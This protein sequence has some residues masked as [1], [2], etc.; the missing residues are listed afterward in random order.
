MNERINEDYTKY[1]EIKG[2]IGGGAFGIVY[3]GIEKK[4]KEL[5]AMKV[6]NLNDYK[7][8]LLEYCKNN[9]IEKQYSQKLEEYKNHLKNEF[10]IMKQLSGNNNSVKCYEY[11]SNDQY[12]VIIMEL[13]DKNLKNW[14]YET[15]SKEKRGF[16]IKEI[17]EILIQLNKILETMKDKCIVH[18]D[19]KPENILIKF[20]DEKAKKYIIKLADYGCSKRLEILSS[21]RMLT[22]EGLGTPLY[23]APEI[24]KKEEINYKCDLWSL[25]III[26]KLYFYNSPISGVNENAIL[27][28]LKSLKNRIK[29]TNNENLDDLISKLLKV[30]KEERLNWDNYFNHPFFKK[31][32]KLNL[33]YEKNNDNDSED[34]IFGKKFVEN[35]NNNIELIINNENKNLIE[36]YK[37]KKGE[38]KIQIIIKGKITN[39]EDMFKGCKNLKNITELNNLDT[40]N[41]NNFS[42][43]FEGC[44]SLPNLN[45]I[46]NWDVSNGKD[47]SHMFDG[48]SSLSNIDELKDWNVSNG[49]NFSFMFCECS[50]LSNL[51]G[52]KNWT[53]SNGKDFCHMFEMCSLLSNVDE[54]KNW[55]VS[56]GKD[57]LFM[58][59]GCSSLSN[60]D[61]L[62]NWKVFNGN[63]F[64]FMF[65]DCSSLSNIDGLEKWDVS[66]GNNFSFMFDECSSLQKINKLENWNV[67]NGKYFSHMFNECSKLS[68]IKGLEKW[69]VSCGEDFSDMFGG[70]LSLTSIKELQNWSISNGKYF[71]YMFRN[72]S[73]LSSS[74][75]NEFFQ[76]HNITR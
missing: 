64:S 34:I 51:N 41:M 19:L 22:T 57:F 14:L 67:S 75:I 74:N 54:L 45:G 18:R 60:I 61:G 42:G 65:S 37:L 33:I 68:N 71:T 50:S 63:N 32:I 52:L 13:C 76:K 59:D 7:E 58:F 35:N 53:V 47:F 16:N 5:R 56:Q 73:S 39:L 44:S 11:F 2:A 1:Y 30:N 31:N 23:M 38:N 12:F 46:E 36:K 70:C 72:C 24:L 15:Y 10:E 62:I 9:N 29:K 3:K 27:E 21:K 20:I 66:A 48:C 69:N 6:I 4:T 26:Y 8:Q 40:K 17:Y 49:I 55:D 25:G 43:M 28:N